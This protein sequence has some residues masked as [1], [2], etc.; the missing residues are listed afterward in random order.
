ML[1]SMTGFGRASGTLAR[2]LT[3]AVTARSVNHKY[4][5]V[6]VRLPEPFWELDAAVRTLAAEVFSRGKVDIAVRLQRTS[7]PEYNIRVNH[8]L[9]TRV[10]P[11]LRGIL[12]EL[13]MPS[14]V[15]VSDLLRV[16][17]LLVVEPNE[18]ELDDAERESFRQIVRDALQKVVEMRQSEAVGLRRDLESRLDAIVTSR[19][20]LEGLRAQVQ[21]E[22]IEG[23]RQRVDELSR[24]AGVDPDRDR[25]AQ[26]TVLLVEKADIAEELTRLAIHIDAVRKTLDGREPAGKKLDFLSQEMLR[27]INT[28]GQKSRA[29]AIRTIVIELKT[30]VER[31][32][33]QVQNV[34]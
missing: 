22:A 13:G 16:P 34:E 10:V 2:G 8:E 31:I 30:E 27:E 4:L 7:E 19:D 28:L 14:G 18:P 23:Y 5:E 21:A 26:E 15:S 17:D 11:Q 12:D 1:Q 20:Q 25:V 3:V 24:I 29:A 9:A 6:S 33:E 32:R